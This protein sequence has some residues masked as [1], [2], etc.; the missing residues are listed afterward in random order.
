PDINRL[1]YSNAGGCIE[2]RSA[3]ADYLRVA[4]SVQCDAD[5]III[6][7]GIHQA[8]DLV[9]RALSDMGDKVWIEDPAYWGM[10][11]T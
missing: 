11:N 10:R 4:R 1:I 7:E 9:S 3:L 6:T 2:L 5:Q 8:I